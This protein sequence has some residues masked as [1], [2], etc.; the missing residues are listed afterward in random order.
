[1]TDI[2]QKTFAD[3]EVGEKAE[4]QIQITEQMINDFSRLSGDYNPLHTD[5]D[6]AK[7]TQFKGVIAHGM[8]TGPLFS[9]LI[10]MYLPGMYSLYI[11]QSIFFHK[12]IN[13]GSNVSVSGEIT[14][15]VD[16]TDVVKISTQIKDSTGLVLVSGEAMVKLLK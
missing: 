10:G 7:T 1:M 4:F 11:S 6:Y 12:P 15:K 3:L 8:I 16:S 9:R 14:Q 13:I 5:R 2:N